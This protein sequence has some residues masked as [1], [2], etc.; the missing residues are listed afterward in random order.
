M[1]NIEIT[2]REILVSI[3][4]VFL[5]ITLGFPLSNKILEGATESYEIHQ[6]ALKVKDSDTFGYAIKTQQ[7][8]L[9]AEGEFE[10]VDPVNF[11]GYKGEFTEITKYKEKYVMKTRYIPEVKDSEGKTI[12]PARTETYWEWDSAGS[13]TVTSK[14]FN[15][16]GQEFNVSD[17]SLISRRSV[18]AKNVTD[19]AKGYYEY[20]GRKVRYYYKIIPVKFN[21]G[22]IAYS[23]ENGL[24]DINGRSKI[25]LSKNNIQEIVESSKASMERSEVVFWMIWILLTGGLIYGYVS[26]ENRYLD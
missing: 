16:L 23:G 7:G 10:S 15:Y 6:K 2:K 26:L 24:K 25:T 4:I 8:N 21:T 22:F 11:P 12:T 13:Q 9:I 1:E 17:F 20:D 19:K 3:I 14:K 5:M 18:D